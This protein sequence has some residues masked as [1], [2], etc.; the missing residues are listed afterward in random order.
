MADVSLTLL[1]LKTRQ[2]DRVRAFYQALG[3]ATDRGF[4]TSER[5]Q[6]RLTRFCAAAALRCYDLLPALRRA[7]SRELYLDQDTHLNADG[8]RVA[9]EQIRDNLGPNEEPSRSVSRVQGDAAGAEVRRLREAAAR[10][11]PKNME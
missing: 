6:D 9:F 1:V 10:H 7:N 8:N 2:V 11:R 5:P 3:I 4:L